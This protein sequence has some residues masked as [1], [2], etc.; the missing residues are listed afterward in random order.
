MGGKLFSVNNLNVVFHRHGQ[1]I[2]VA[3]NVSFS[4]ER[5]QALALV[6]ESGCGKTV[7]GLA[8]TGQLIG[9]HGEV[10]GDIDWHGVDLAKTNCPVS[11]I[12]QNP[13]T[14]LNPVLTVKKQLLDLIGYH[15]K[16]L[17]KQAAMKKMKELLE[18]SGI[19]RP[20]EVTDKYPWELSGGM[21]QRVCIA[22]A[23]SCK[24]RLLIADEPTTALDPVTGVSVMQT[25]QKLRQQ[26]DLAV[27][28]ISHDLAMVAHYS[29]KILFLYKGRVMEYGLNRAVLSEPMHPYS[30]KLLNTFQALQD[31]QHNLAIID[32]VVPSYA[33]LPQGCIFRP[34]CDC[35]TED[36][37][38]YHPELL[39]CADGRK[40]AC[41]RYR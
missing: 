20:E 9:N 13:V 10:T 37:R 31:K 38:L 25:L 35:T 3:D 30:Q 34:R 29:E 14:A 19:T 17:L 36:C 28:L 15:H 8:I 22:M 41:H 39:V 11:M 12:Y 33:S 2:K 40:V 21:A 1:K 7:T 18:L 24:P 5:G 27:I 23:L 6:G 26:L 4:L 16:P 32:G